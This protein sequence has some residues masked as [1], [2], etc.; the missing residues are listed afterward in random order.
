M[1]RIV[2]VMVGLAFLVLFAIGARA[3]PLAKSGTGT[4]HSGY[5]AVGTTT[6]IGEDRM[7]WTGAYWGLSFNDEGKGFLHQVAW[8]C[9]AITD[10]HNKTLI[11]KGS[12]ALTDKDGDKLYSDW[13]G[14]GPVGGEFA[15]KVTLSGGTGKYTGVQGGWEFQCWSVG[16]DGQLHCRQ[17]YNYKLP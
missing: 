15:G 1:N 11:T 9:P 4:V 3:Q 8:H 6:P 7:Y 17:K 16:S 12:C 10:I 13:T 5:K 2:T 14:T